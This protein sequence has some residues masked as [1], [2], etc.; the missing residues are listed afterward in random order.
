MIQFLKIPKTCPACGGEVSI[1]KDNNSEVLYCENPQCQGKLINRLDYFCGKKG[2]NIKGLSKATL[3]K[4]IDYG[5]ISSYEDIFNLFKYRQEWIKKSGFGEK[6]V[7]NILEAID[8]S[9]KVSLSN[10]I[11][12]LGIPFI[13]KTA[14]VALQKY[15]KTYQA[16]REAIETKSLDFFKIK[17][18]GEVMRNNLISFDFSEADSLVKNY[19]IIEENKENNNTAELEG[20]IFVITGK[21]FNFKNRDELKSFIESKGGKVATTISKNTSYLINND[22]NSNSAKNVKAQKLGIPILKEKEF[23]NLI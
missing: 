15:F 5:W 4:L 10:F 19:L 13:G 20:L 6:S 3:E 22:I 2:L 9:K 8:N 18:F 21:I 17:D 23:L 12:A 1:H 7:N 11:A 14:S 16:L